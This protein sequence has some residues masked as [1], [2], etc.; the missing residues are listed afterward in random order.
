MSETD[1]QRWQRVKEIFEG[2]LDRHG[3]ERD[4]F[5]DGACDGNTEVR[6]EVESLLRS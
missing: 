4:S 6:N 3:V 1:P 2:A 5:L